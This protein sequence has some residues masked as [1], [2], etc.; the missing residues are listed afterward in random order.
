MDIYTFETEVAELDD[1]WMRARR[2]YR[3]FSHDGVLSSDP[4][5]YLDASVRVLFLLKEAPEGAYA[6][7]DDGGMMIRGIDVDSASKGSCKAFWK[8]IGMWTYVIDHLNN[9][10]DPDI[11][12]FYDSH[13]DDGYSLSNVAYVNIKKGNGRPS[14]NWADLKRYARRD[15]DFLNE[16]VDLLDPDV[17]VCCHTYRLYA[18]NVCDGDIPYG[19]Q[20]SPVYDEV[21]DRIVLDWY[22]PAE[23]SSDNADFWEFKKLCEQERGWFENI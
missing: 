22:H 1:R 6:E 10:E 7:D 12:E 15:R 16:Q 21:N 5:D 23:R 2:N 9:G 14:S 4:S 8:R 18:E 11:G 13:N 3:A 17:I 20:M 19:G